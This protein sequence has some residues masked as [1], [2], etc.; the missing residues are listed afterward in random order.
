MPDDEERSFNDMQIGTIFRELWEERAPI[1]EKWRVRR[2]LLDLIADTF[3]AGVGTRHGSGR[4]TGG[5]QT[6]TT[7]VHPY[8]ES[9]MIIRSMI[10]DVPEVAANFQARIAANEPQVTVVP[11]SLSA[12]GVGKQI[13]DKAAE[14]ERLLMS[15][16]QAKKGRIGQYMI[17][18]MQAWAGV[19]WYFTLPLDAS[20]GLPDREYF[21][22]LTDDDLEAMKRNGTAVEVG[23]RHAEPAKTWME[24]RRKTAAEVAI[25]HPA[26][27]LVT[28]EAIPPDMVLP[29]YDHDGTAGRSLKYGFIVEEIP[30][31]EF[32]QGGAIAMEIAKA[33]GITD[34]EAIRRYGITLT[35]DKVSGGVTA[36]GEPFSQSGPN[37]TWT[38][39]RFVTREEIYYYVTESPGIGTGKTIFYD[40]HGGGAC[41]LVPVPAL[42]SDSGR[43]GRE[44]A[45]LMDGIFAKAPILNQIETLLSN[46][47]TW[48]ALGRFVIENVDQ[49]LREDPDNTG[50]PL[51]LTKDDIIGLDP[52]DVSIVNGTIRQLDIKADLLL[53]LMEFY[54]QRLDQAKPSPV[55]EGQSGASAAAWQ[56][57]QL[58]EASGELLAQAVNNHAAAVQEVMLLWIR[59]LRML[60]EPVFVF[61]V[62][63]KR[64]SDQTIRGLIEFDPKDLIESI[65]V[66]QSPQ[67]AQQR[68]VLDQVGAEKLA[69]GLIDDRE[70]YEEFALKADPVEA[71]QRATIQ[72]VK[73]AVLFGDPTFAPPGSLMALIV[74]MVKGRVTM[75]MLDQSPAFAIA[76]A[77]QMAAESFAAAQVPQVGDGNVAQAAGVVQPGLGMGVELPGTAGGQAPAGVA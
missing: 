48:N 75:Q 32:Q 18:R 15:M 33:T 5:Q 29:R 13:E 58:L 24:R 66:T 49:T 53:K 46:V 28:L 34:D 67:S 10:G 40:R 57:R 74:E 73:S 64:G 60:N 69:Q 31:T 68:V 37:E 72:K 21:D 8:D 61:G 27:A 76:T 14:Q 77:Q 1:L 65:S 39:A 35:D 45:S 44:F 52:G 6:G 51:I 11:L 47:A 20:W 22:E 55:T 30:T 59:W 71:E 63:G 62:P 26:R 41:P 38:L 17:A 43:P 70:Y 36:G 16:W 56:V 4:G 23:E 2:M 9:E 19:G 54:S 42:H 50:E 12:Q 3:G 25:S 7:L